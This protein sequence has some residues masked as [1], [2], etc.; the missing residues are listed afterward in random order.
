MVC[1]FVRQ[2]VVYTNRDRGFQYLFHVCVLIE[3][4]YISHVIKLIKHFIVSFF[5][6]SSLIFN[7]EYVVDLIGEP[8]NVNDPDSSI[9]GRLL[10][11]V[12]SPFQVSH[13]MGCKDYYTP[14]TCYSQQLIREHKGVLDANSKHSGIKSLSLS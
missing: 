10:S 8:G 4:R 14:N 1:I 13:L 2:R 11:F 9:N 6:F 7:R 5:S 12:P 3:L